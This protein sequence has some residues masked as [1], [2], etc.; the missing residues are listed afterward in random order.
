MVG[1]PRRSPASGAGVRSRTAAPGA[2]LTGLVRGAAPDADLA[3]DLVAGGHA[4]FA[5]PVEPDVVLTPDP[6]AETAEAT[7]RRR[8]GKVDEPAEPTPEP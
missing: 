4:T 6:P 7:P 8:G 1:V 3:A 5:E 2:L